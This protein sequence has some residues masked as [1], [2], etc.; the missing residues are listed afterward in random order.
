[1]KKIFEDDEDI[2]KNRAKVAPGSYTLPKDS[3]GTL[4]DIHNQIDDMGLGATEDDYDEPLD[5]DLSGIG[6]NSQEI[7]IEDVDYDSADLVW[8]EVK[9]F[10]GYHQFKRYMDP[11]FIKYLGIDSGELLVAS[12]LSGTSVENILK[13]GKTILN[14]GQILNNNADIIKEIQRPGVYEITKC[15]VVAYSGNTYMLI[16]ELHHG[17]TKEYYI[18]ASPIDMRGGFG[19]NTLGRP[20]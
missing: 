2:M 15:I 20:N 6:H 10:P 4:A 18:Y 17:E 7:P 13:A 12:K 14:N 5:L 9:Q 8:Y 11:Y 16:E 19:V 1:M 3:A